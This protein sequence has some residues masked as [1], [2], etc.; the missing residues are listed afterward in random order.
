MKRSPWWCS[1]SLMAMALA[2]PLAA[3]EAEKSIT[4]RAGPLPI[5]GQALSPSCMQRRNEMN[6]TR[7]SGTVVPGEK[8]EIKKDGQATLCGVKIDFHALNGEVSV[9]GPNGKPTRLRQRGDGV[10]SIPVPLPNKRQAVIAIPV[11]DGLRG[12][13]ELFFRSG[14]AMTG[15]L[16]GDS[17]A[18]YDDDLDGAIVTGKD[19]FSVGSGIV[20]APL[21]EWLPTSKGL[22]K[23]GS[24][25]ETGTRLTC[26]A[27]GESTGKL[28]L[29][30]AGM[31]GVEAHAVFGTKGCDAVLTGRK[32]M[33][34]PAGSYQLRYG[35]LVNPSARATYAGIVAADLAAVE[36]PSGGDKPAVVSIG[37]PYRIDFKV[38]TPNRK[39][40]IDPGSFRLFGKAGERYVD[41]RFKGAPAVAV[42][43][44][45]IGSFEY[46]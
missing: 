42:N 36:V 25:D 7:R 17:I 8:S 37:G 45:N 20:F 24:V 28:E 46:G 43:G 4:L 2:P 16:D 10:D 34:V 26:Q 27:S 39:V 41:Y 31:P 18:L 21:G 32:P 30:N 19:A 40:T 9:V 6:L 22:F 5:D 12:G 38:S 15:Q 29:K 13:A 14:Q 35:L 33:V 1:A 11:V 23:V 44:K 3:Q